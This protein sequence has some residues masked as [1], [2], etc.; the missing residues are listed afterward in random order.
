MDIDLTEFE[1]DAS[2][3][4]LAPIAPAPVSAPRAVPPPGALH[5]PDSLYTARPGIELTLELPGSRE[6]PPLDFD[7]SQFDD[8]PV[9]EPPR[10]N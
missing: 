6:L 4:S 3:L 7:T 5:A 8:D 1:S 9:G 10:R 2:A